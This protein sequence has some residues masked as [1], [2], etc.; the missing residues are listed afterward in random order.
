MCFLKHVKGNL[1][2]ARCFRE[3]HKDDAR[4]QRPVGRREGEGWRGESGG[5]GKRG[6]ERERT[7]E[8]IKEGRKA[9]NNTLIRVIYT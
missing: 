6:R 8:K 3:R 9:R 4:E 1:A 7:K 5:G 2:S